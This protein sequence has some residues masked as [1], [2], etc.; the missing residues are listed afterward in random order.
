MNSL[1]A[2]IFEAVDAAEKKGVEAIRVSDLKSYL[3]D[4]DTA[5]GDVG[6]ENIAAARLEQYK[7]ELS[8]WLEHHKNEKQWQFELFRSTIVAGQSALRAAILINGGA[9][10]ALLAFIGNLWETNPP[11]AN[12]LARPLNTFLYGVLAAAAAAGTTYVSQWFYFG[13]GTRAGWTGNV[14]TLITVTLVAASY[15]YFLQ[16]ITV[17][18]AAFGT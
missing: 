3:T 16:G 18:N 4:L 6:V 9:A 1:I 15:W 7:V 13:G 8:R 17:A 11:V 2:T 14:F 10:V 12:D 5:V